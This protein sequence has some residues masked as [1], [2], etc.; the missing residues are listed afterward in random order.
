MSDF[1]IMCDAIVAD[2]VANVAALTVAEL[3]KLSPWDPELL[4]VSDGKRHLA[5]WPAPGEM[6][7]QGSLTNSSHLLTQYYQ[8]LVWEPAAEEPGRGT[9]DDVATATFLNLHNDIRAR[10][11]VETNQLLGESS[12][13]WYSGTRLPSDP[14]EQGQS[15]WFL[16]TLSSLRMISFT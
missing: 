12:R 10:F 15:R 8:V 16:M 4:D 7:V 1:S 2:L 13:L 5:V 11:Y 14:D 6:E 3:H 9:T